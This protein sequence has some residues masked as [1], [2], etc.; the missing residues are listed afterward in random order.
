MNRVIL[1]NPVH[2]CDY[3][4]ASWISNNIYLQGL[5]TFIAAQGPLSQ[6]IPHFLQMMIENKVQAIVMLTELMEGGK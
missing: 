1:L 6:S 3:I 2:G 5:P 4:N